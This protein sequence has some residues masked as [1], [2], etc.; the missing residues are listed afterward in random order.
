M[1]V[2]TLCSRRETL[3]VKAAD[4]RQESHATWLCLVEQGSRRGLGLHAGDS[5]TGGQV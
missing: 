5:P 2:V 3:V 4:G 1:K